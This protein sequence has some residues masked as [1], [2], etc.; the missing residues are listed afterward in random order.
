MGV[1]F[2]EITHPYCPEV[3]G[4]LATATGESGVRDV[5]VHADHAFVVA[6]TTDHGMQV[7]DLRRLLD[8]TEPPVAFDADAWH[9]GFGRA[10]NLAIDTDSGFAYGV[11]I[12]ACGQG[13]YIMDIG[14]PVMPTFVG[15]HPPPG[16]HIHDTLCVVYDGPDAEHQGRQICIDSNGYSG[17][18]SVIDV[19]DKAAIEVLAEAPY[20][21]AAYTHQAWL[22]DDH[23]YLLVNDELDELT[24]G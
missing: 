13:L 20:P 5:K 1:A 4:F 7:F 24:A 12:G 9:T 2:V 21:D 18:I 14:D 3:T 6:E 23:A 10:H 8:V 15:C 16:E 17:S 11:A 19:T 22:T